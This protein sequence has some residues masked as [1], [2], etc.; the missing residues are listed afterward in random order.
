MTKRLLGLAACAVVAAC[1]PMDPIGDL[2]GRV[3]TWT[4]AWSL[5]RNP[6]LLSV[7]LTIEA[8][9]TVTGT[10]RNATTNVNGVINAHM[11]ASGQFD[12]TLDFETGA[13]FNVNGTANVAPNDHLIG[14]FVQVDQQTTTMVT[15]TFDLTRM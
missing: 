9:G 5:S 14:N 10:I 6:E 8:D 12:G 7:Q 13:D 4:G 15:G 3:G 11:S 1:N 2:G